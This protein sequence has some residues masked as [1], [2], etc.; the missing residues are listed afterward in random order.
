MDPAEQFASGYLGMG[1]NPVMMVDPDGEI[2][3]AIVPALLIGAATSAAGYTASVAFSD[4]GFDNWDWGDFGKSAAIGAVS[5][6]ATAGIG[7]VFGV[8]LNE[9]R[10]IG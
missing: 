7:E 6:V 3:F 9:I 2:V 1:N 10:A 5:G 8:I 4:G